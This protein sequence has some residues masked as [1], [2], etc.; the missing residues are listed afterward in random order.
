MRLTFAQL[1]LTVGAFDANFERIRQAVAQAE[2][3]ESDLVVFSELATTGYP[4]RDLV[5]HPRFVDANLDLLERVA[6]LS[7]AR[8]GILIGFVDRNDSKEGKPLFNAVAYCR[9]GRVAERR[10]K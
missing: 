1:N 2:A 7:T 4:P 3:D 10:Y 8:L 6:K 5:T 9:H